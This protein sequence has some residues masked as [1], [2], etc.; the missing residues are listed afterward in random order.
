MSEQSP[1]ELGGGECKDL[2][3]PPD[4]IAAI[5]VQIEQL[6]V[7]DHLDKLVLNIKRSYADVFK[8]IPHVDQML[9]SVL[10]KIMLKDAS[11]TICTWSYSCPCKF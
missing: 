3:K 1:I 4:I 7:K 10:C 9:D 5:H 2:V 11:K 8:P 6:A